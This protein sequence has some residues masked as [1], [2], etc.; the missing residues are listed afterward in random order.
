MRTALARAH[1]DRTN[2]QHGLPI[3]NG[4]GAL[5]DDVR[6]GCQECQKKCSALHRAPLPTVTVPPRCRDT[7]GIDRG[8]QGA[9]TATSD[10]S[11]E[12]SG[13]SRRNPGTGKG[14]TLAPKNQQSNFGSR[15]WRCGRAHTRARHATEMPLHATPLKRTVVD[16]TR[17]SFAPQVMAAAAAVAACTLEEGLACAREAGQPSISRAPRRLAM[18]MPVRMKARSYRIYKVEKT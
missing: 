11:D 5:R 18:R 8:P 7:N 2:W 12:R 16:R 6:L 15:S 13:A 3:L 1:A 9:P 10:G 17:P 4:L 14:L